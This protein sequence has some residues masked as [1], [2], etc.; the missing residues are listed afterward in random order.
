MSDA[1]PPAA[2]APAEAAS[3]PPVIPW[4]YRAVVFF[5]TLPV[6]L[7][8]Q[9]I[10]VHGREHVPPPGTPLIV[11]GNHRTNLDPFLIARS[12]PPGRHLQFMAKK[13]LFVPVIGHIIRAGGSFPVDRQANDLGAVRTSLRI[14]QAGGTLGI[15]PEGTRGGGE[16]QGGV[17]LLALKGK[18]PVLPVGLSREGR[19]W[20]VRFG[21]PMAPTGG[22]KALTAAIGERLTELAGPVGERPGN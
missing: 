12:L 8:G 11:A 5:T 17:A 19:R 10:E 7:R 9:R 4:V 20:I 6:F 14:L 2:T 13:E 3:A 16:M 22:I 1:R 21:E 15:F 18:A